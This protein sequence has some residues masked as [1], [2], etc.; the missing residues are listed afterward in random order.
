MSR[1]TSFKIG[2]PADLFL[3]PDSSEQISR[4]ISA[5]RLSSIPLY[6]IG[7]GSDLLVH[8]EGVRGAVLAV[9]Q[10]L[11]QIKKLDNRTLSSGAGA[12]LERVCRF[13]LEEG[14]S[15]LEF[16]YGIPGSVGGA[17]YMNAGAYGGEM[18]DVLLG[19]AHIDEDGREGEFSADQ[20]N[21][22]YRRS[23]YTECVCCITSAVFRLQP[24][25]PAEIHA[26]MEDLK[27]RRRTKQPLEYPSAG[28]TFKRPKGSYASALIDQCGLKGL[29]IGGAMVSEKH[30][31]FLINYDHATCEDVLELIE[32]VRETVFRQ[33]GYQLECEVKLI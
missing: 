24:G 29:R 22:S 30:A 1:H 15:G 10:K 27:N 18:R 26:R 33:T 17:V 23:V 28:S 2:G 14:L 19:T 8:D 12:S 25:D 9:T 7:R 20:L 13:A 4:L 32:K 11:S 21:L 5:A 6:I 3:L 16:A 31:G